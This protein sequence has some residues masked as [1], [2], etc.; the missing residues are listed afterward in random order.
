[1]KQKTEKVFLIILLLAVFSACSKSDFGEDYQIHTENGSTSIMFT[2]LQKV[3]FITEYMKADRDLL[4]LFGEENIYFGDTPPIL[5]TS[6]QP[7]FQFKADDGIYAL[8]K[9]YVGG[10]CYDIPRAGSIQPIKYYHRFYEQSESIIKYM[11]KTVE[12][13]TEHLRSVDSVFLMG[14]DNCF[15]AFYYETTDTPGHPLNAII[16]SGI[17]SNEGVENYRYGVKIVKYTTEDY[18]P[19]SVFGEGSIH[20]FMERDNHI[21]E[22]YQ[23]YREPADPSGIIMP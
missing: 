23:W 21:A 16:I 11:C 1:M 19:S 2:D 12:G 6:D 20:I 17:K 7:E 8:A 5:C 4:E 14:H 10:N 15:T 9:S 18:D 3:P 22:W 13:E